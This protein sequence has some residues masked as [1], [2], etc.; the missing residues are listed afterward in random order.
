MQAG[1]DRSVAVLV[2]R[3]KLLDEVM[4]S[5]DALEER[6]SDAPLSGE[7]LLGYHTQRMDFWP[8][9]ETLKNT[10]ESDLANTTDQNS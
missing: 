9:A 4:N 1:S 10:A 8:A 5:L 2:K 6:T 3:R 7:F